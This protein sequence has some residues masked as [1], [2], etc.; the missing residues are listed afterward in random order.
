VTR[1]IPVWLN[2]PYPGSIHDIQCCRIGGIL[3]K[4][5]RNEFIFGDKGYAEKQKIITSWQ[6]QGMK[7]IRSIVENTIG[8]IKFF[9]CLK[10]PWRH[11]I[12]L[13]HIVFS[14]ATQII[15]L[16]MILDLLGSL[17]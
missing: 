1:G 3:N 9:R 16:E 4:L 6:V 10:V 2:G 14:I 15:A 7:P 5:E 8:R 13:H 11:D 17:L 12:A